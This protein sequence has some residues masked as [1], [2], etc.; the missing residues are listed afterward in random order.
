MLDAVAGI[1]LIKCPVWKR[2]AA[3]ICNVVGWRDDVECF[4]AGEWFGAGAD[5]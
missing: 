3:A 1:D 4:V 5:F 2:Q